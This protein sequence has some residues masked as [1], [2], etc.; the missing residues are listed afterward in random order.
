MKQRIK[1]T[2][3]WITISI[4]W[5]AIRKYAIRAAI[6]KCNGNKDALLQLKNNLYLVF[7]KQHPNHWTTKEFT[8]IIDKEL[9][10]T[11]T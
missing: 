2:L 1:A 11:E 10:E 5:L 9:Y 3:E 6:G 8:N 4:Q 7:F